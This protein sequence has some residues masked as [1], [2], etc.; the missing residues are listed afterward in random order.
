MGYVLLG[1]HILIAAIAFFLKR[2]NILQIDYLMWVILLC[3]PVWG[4]F[5]AVIISVMVKRN[6][7]GSLR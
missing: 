1:V 6:L 2:K 3:I 4:L 7:V 5:S